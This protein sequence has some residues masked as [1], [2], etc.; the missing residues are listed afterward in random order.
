M[1]FV[2]KP[3]VD[4]SGVGMRGL[5]FAG[6]SS[7]CAT[8]DALLNG[9]VGDQFLI[10]TGAGF[11]RSE[12]KVVPGF[13]EHARERVK[14]CLIGG[15]FLC[16]GGNVAEKALG[17]GEF[18]AAV[19]EETTLAP[20]VAVVVNAGDEMG[21]VGIEDSAVSTLGRRAAFPGHVKI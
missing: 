11:A 10:I 17:V 6:A 19:G 18:E 13:R 5:R 7:Q 8:L 2:V 20:A 1:K 15:A 3:L 21:V 4:H 9:D 16:C 12:V 14:D